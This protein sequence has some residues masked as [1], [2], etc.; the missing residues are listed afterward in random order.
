MIVDAVTSTVTTITDTTGSA[1]T[2]STSAFTLPNNSFIVLPIANYSIN[3]ATGDAVYTIGGGAEISFG[4]PILNQGSTNDKLAFFVTRVVTGGTCVISIKNCSYDMCPPIILTGDAHYKVT[5]T[6]AVDQASI[7]ENPASSGQFPVASNGLT[8]S[9]NTEIPA[10]VTPISSSKV[11]IAILTHGPD[12][13][14][15]TITPGGTWTTRDSVTDYDGSFQPATIIYK[16]VP[17]NNAV[18]ADIIINQSF[19]YTLTQIIIED[20]PEIYFVPGYGSE[21]SAE[22]ECWFGHDGKGGPDDF[23]RIDFDPPIPT[24]YGVV[25]PQST[26]GGDPTIDM[27]S[28]SGGNTWTLQPGQVAYNSSGG[29]GNGGSLSVVTSVLTN[30]MS[31]FE[32]DASGKPAAANFKYGQLGAYVIKNPGTGF[33]TI[34]P[35]TNTQ[36]VASNIAP[37][38]STPDYSLTFWIFLGNNRG[39]TEN[40]KPYTKPSGYTIA[41]LIHPGIDG[42]GAESAVHNSITQSGWWFGKLVTGFSAETPSFI[43]NGGNTA[44]A[45]SMLIGFNILG[46]SPPAGAPDFQLVNNLY[47]PRR[48]TMIGY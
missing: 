29:D 32:Y 34:T 11:A 23:A 25:V 14:V 22:K 2:R 20:A 35:V 47:I 39:H 36:F 8:P 1:A 31:Q 5:F 19:R 33:R 24:G 38:S 48:R 18:V 28:D 21:N 30:P 7:T 44:E 12:T 13:G 15:P 16:Q 45:R 42:D 3:H 41:H 43:F 9:W 17:D 40:L 4:A 26:F 10:N 6:T 37:G 46:G 27:W